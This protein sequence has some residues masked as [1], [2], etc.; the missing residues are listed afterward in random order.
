MFFFVLHHSSVIRFFFILTIMKFLH[1]STFNFIVRKVFYRSTLPAIITEG[2]AIEF[3]L[4]CRYSCNCNLFEWENIM[5]NESVAG[6]VLS[7]KR[8]RWS[9]EWCFTLTCIW[10]QSLM[11]S[12]WPARVAINGG[13]YEQNFISNKEI[14]L[15]GC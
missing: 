15:M 1:I 6:I 5:I 8:L 13:G 9:R 4:D 11:H 3:L 7:L 10:V 14:L 12:V 2:I